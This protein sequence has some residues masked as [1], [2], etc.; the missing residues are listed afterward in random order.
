MGVKEKKHKNADE[1]LKIIEEILDSNKN[2]QNFFSVASKVHKG[3]SEPKPE[4]SIA[5]R[6]H[7]RREKAAKVKREEKT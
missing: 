5:K 1:T 3:K 2:S 4:E 6:V 7:L